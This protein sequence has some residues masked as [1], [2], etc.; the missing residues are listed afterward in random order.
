MDMALACFRSG[1]T[2]QAAGITG[3]LKS[4]SGMWFRIRGTD[5][6]GCQTGRMVTATAI[7]RII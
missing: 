3:T 5:G 7:S 1:E 6:N 2:V 4:H